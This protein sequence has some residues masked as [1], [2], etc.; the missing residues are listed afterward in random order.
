MIRIIDNN[1][2]EVTYDESYAVTPGQVCCLYDNE[3][4]LGGGIIDKVY[5]NDE[6]RAFF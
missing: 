2:L 3:V 5:Y 6:I 1:T 4:C